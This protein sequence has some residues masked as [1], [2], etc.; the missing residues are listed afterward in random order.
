MIINSL[1]FILG[2]VFL[3]YGADILIK[4]SKSVAV[5]YNI[6]PI[7]IGITIVAVGTSLP[8]LIVSVLAN[9]KGDAGMV[10]GNVMGSNIA[11][12]GL[13]LGSTVIISPIFFNFEKI[14][15]DMYFLVIITILPL[16]C[17]ISGE[18]VFWQGIV[19]IICFIIYC[20]YLMQSNQLNESDNN[21]KIEYNFRLVFVEILFG[22]I[23]LSL[24]ATLFVD[25]AQGIAIFFGFSS[26]VIGMTIVALG[27]SLPELAAS[28][29][30]A[31]HGETDFII[32]NIIGSNIMN[33]VLVLGIS[34]LFENIVVQS[35]EILI[36]GFFMIFLTFNLF[37]LLKWRGTINKLSGITFMIL[38]ILFLYFNFQ[39]T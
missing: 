19:L 20:M 2:A 31:K 15:F 18:L 28:I 26:I 30:A 12:I 25:G 11:N 17:M 4:G 37:F 13:V 24:G 23:G 5:K 39:S 6:S 1:Q 10:I 16:W 3:Y 29:A 27:T 32:G 8:E 38:Y 35:S 36:Q 34:L 7:I 33:I 21:I 9:I 14:R 22:I